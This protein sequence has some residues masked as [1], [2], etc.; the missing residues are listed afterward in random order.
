VWLVPAVVT[1]AVGLAAVQVLPTAE[2]STET[3][4]SHAGLGASSYHFLPSHLILLLFPYLF[5]NSFSVPP[6]HTLYRGVWNPWELAGYPGLAAVALG[7][8]GLPRIRR[9]PR[10]LAMSLAAGFSL[11][12]ALGRTTGAGVLIAFVPVYGQ[13][14]AWARDAVVVDL[15]VALFA[16]YGVT[17]LR[18]AAGETL[19]AAVRRTWATVALLVAIGVLVPLIPAVSQYA[20]GGTE[21]LLAIGVPLLFAA[22]GASCVWLFGRSRRAALALCCAVVAL[23]GLASFGAYFEWRRSPSPETAASLYSAAVPAD[24]GAVTPRPGG[25][26]RFLVAAG[27]PR[28]LPQTTM[29]PS[30]PYYPQVT[31]VKRL[32]S[33]NGYGPLIPRR[34]VDVVGGMSDNG[35]L[36]RPGQFTRKRSW[37]L[38]VLRVSTVLVPRQEAPRVRPRWF[39]S[40]TAVQGFVRYTYTPRLPDAFLVGSVRLVAPRTA[41]AAGRGEV[42][43]DP[44]RSALVEGR[45]APCESMTRP[46]IAGRVSARWDAHS[47]RGGVDTARPALLVV[48]QSWAPGWTA[49]VDALGLRAGSGAAQAS[50]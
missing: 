5:G 22:V 23:D 46:G 33:V 20:V 37:L 39:D 40:S 4:R 35:L 10:A 28:S 29:V 25:M 30:S 8:A 1:V 50:T 31:D 49:S 48:S 18:A 38:D 45:C 12:L 21:R 43:F 13:F 16:A 44:T 7:V 6:F 11:L 26:T 47:L 34:Y 2:L 27:V 19:R 36:H 42:A 41:V 3:I 24:W 32:R 17:H 15:A 9:D 14:R